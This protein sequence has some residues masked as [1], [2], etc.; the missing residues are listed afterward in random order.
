MRIAP[1]GH[2]P[3]T[4]RVDPGLQGGKFKEAYSC[5]YKRALYLKPMGCL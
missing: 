4:Q 1:K 5:L 2:Q 3:F